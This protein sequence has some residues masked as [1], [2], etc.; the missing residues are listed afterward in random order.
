MIFNRIELARHCVPQYSTSAFYQG[1]HLQFY[2][3]STLIKWKIDK[4]SL[5]SLNRS[6]NSPKQPR[7]FINSYP[8]GSIFSSVRSVSA[9]PHFY[10]ILKCWF[11]IR[12]V[13]KEGIQIRKKASI[14]INPD[15]K[16][17]LDTFLRDN[18]TSLHVGV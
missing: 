10:L 6:K 11:K 9:D 4:F 15:H 3:L 12:T 2:P 14:R 7:L 18:S 8:G 1:L 16:R 13:K 5:L 17:F